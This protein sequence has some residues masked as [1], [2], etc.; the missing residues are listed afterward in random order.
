[1]LQHQAQSWTVLVKRYKRDVRRRM[2]AMWFGHPYV[3][4]KKRKWHWR[5]LCTRSSLH[6]SSFPSSQSVFDKHASWVLRRG[7]SCC[8]LRGD[9]TPESAALCKRTSLGQAC[10]RG[11]PPPVPPLLYHPDAGCQELPWR[12]RLNCFCHSHASSSF[13]LF[14]S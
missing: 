3:V 13:F 12:G 8:P 9:L 4:D 11:G 7:C 5:L 14:S 1:M 10:C 2:W 6:L